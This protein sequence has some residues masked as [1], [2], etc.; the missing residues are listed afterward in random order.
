MLLDGAV[1]LIEFVHFRC[2]SKVSGAVFVEKWLCDEAETD[3]IFVIFSPL[4]QFLDKFFSTQK[5]VNHD[6]TDFA[7]QL[8]KLQKNWFY[9][10]IA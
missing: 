3:L 8:H 4:M 6:T 2:S 10:K 1:C 9:N 5:C 7:T